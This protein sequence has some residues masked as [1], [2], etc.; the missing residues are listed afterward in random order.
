VVSTAERRPR[1]PRRKKKS[2]VKKNKKSGVEHTHRSEWVQ[3]PQKHDVMIARGSGGE[4]E[5]ETGPAE[6]VNKQRGPARRGRK[7]GS[8]CIPGV[9]A[10]VSGGWLKEE[11]SYNN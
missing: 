2:Y 11:V 9:P 6:A 5:G 1:E 10:R 8:D 3:L 4:R 7:K